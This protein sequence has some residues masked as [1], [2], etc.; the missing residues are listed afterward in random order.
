MPARTIEI[1]E[2]EQLFTETS[3]AEQKRR[4]REEV[5]L[6][7]QTKQRYKFR[8]QFCKELMDKYH[9]VQFLKD[10]DSLGVY[11]SIERDIPDQPNKKERVHVA[12]RRV[13]E[14]TAKS[15]KD[16]G[17]RVYVRDMPDGTKIYN[18]AAPI[19]YEDIVGYLKVDPQPVTQLLNQLIGRVN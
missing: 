9:R 17:V 13:D 5:A 16:K 11:V 1:S 12:T 14:V 18:V 10:P 15:L 2:G 4:N 6:W 19:P 7:T 8:D 3:E